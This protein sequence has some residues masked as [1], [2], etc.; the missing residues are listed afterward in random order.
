[1]AHHGST[2]AK[3]SPSTWPDPRRGRP[4]RGAA[5]L[6]APGCLQ[7]WLCP[8]Q[9][10]WAIVANGLAGTMLELDE[11]NR[12]AR[13]IPQIRVLPP[14]WRRPS[15]SGDRGAAPSDRAGGGLRRGGAAGGGAPVP[16]ARDAHARRSPRALGRAAAAVARLRSWTRTLPPGARS[17]CRP[18]LW[19]RPRNSAAADDP[20]GTSIQGLHA[21]PTAGSLAVAGITPL[22]EHASRDL[23]PDTRFP[24]LDAAACSDGSASARSRTTTSSATLA[25]VQ[26]PRRRSDRG[27]PGDD[28]HRARTDRVDPRRATCGPRSHDDQ[29]PVGA[30]GANFWIRRLPRDSSLAS[31][32]DCGVE[33]F[34][35]PA[36]SKAPPGVWPGGSRS[37]R[38]P[39]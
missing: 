2:R 27:A 28:A 1:M 14:L 32:G 25:A 22:A 33:A 24:G 18:P 23:R 5:E 6:P 31:R 19:G 10:W 7:G 11:G 37:W 8:R 29:D 36:L 35:E 26:P 38:I 3:P 12:F 21:G 16:A 17:G 30:L 34:R 39:R 4:R 15:G 9:P 20:S 13:V